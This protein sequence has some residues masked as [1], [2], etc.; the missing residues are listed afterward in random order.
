MKLEEYIIEPELLKTMSV[1]LTR[2]RTGLR[3][4]AL[5]Q[6]RPDA[7]FLE[8]DISD[9]TVLAEMMKKATSKVKS[10]RRTHTSENSSRTRRQ[11]PGTG[12][13]IRNR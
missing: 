13:R 5:E 6:H 2:M 1:R 4:V 7:L 3:D 8:E 10:T 9:V 11:C 12:A